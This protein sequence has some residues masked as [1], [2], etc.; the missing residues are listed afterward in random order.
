V[1]LSRLARIDLHGLTPTQRPLAACR[2][3]SSALESGKT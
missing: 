3:G 2:M 1:D